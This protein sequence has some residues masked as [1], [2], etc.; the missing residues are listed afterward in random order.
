MHV[1]PLL[2]I[3][4]IMVQLAILRLTVPYLGRSHDI[5]T[6]PSKQKNGGNSRLKASRLTATSPVHNTSRA[7]QGGTGHDSGT[8]GIW[9]AEFWKGG[10]AADLCTN[11]WGRCRAGADGWAP[12]VDVL[13]RCWDKGRDGR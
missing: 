13:P 11:L 10:R 3:L 12:R 1:I 6:P 2:L 8:R 4:V 5:L 7:R 9:W